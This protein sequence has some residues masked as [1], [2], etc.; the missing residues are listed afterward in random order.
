MAG[1]KQLL[2]SFT[3]LLIGIA[4]TLK[5]WDKIAHHPVIGSIILAFGIIILLYF[6]YLNLK[7]HPNE[8]LD[9]IV[10]WFE[11]IA[12]LFTAYIYYTEG[13]RYLHFVFLLAAIGFFV[14]IYIH[15]RKKE[16]AEIKTIH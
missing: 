11:G 4:L 1:K 9:L 16:H 5:G 12:A 8:K 3:H 2:Q 13:S 14:S 15:H 6:F 7:K 10:H